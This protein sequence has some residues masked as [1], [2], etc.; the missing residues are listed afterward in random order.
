MLGRDLRAGIVRREHGDAIGRNADVA[1][2]QGQHALADAAEADEDQSSRKVDVYRV[3]GHLQ[4][5][6]ANTKSGRVV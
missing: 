1:H 2:D 6:V 4:T 3:V 5:A